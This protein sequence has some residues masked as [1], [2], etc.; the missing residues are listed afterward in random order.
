MYRALCLN[1]AT[2]RRA[3]PGDE[4]IMMPSCLVG[5]GKARNWKPKIILVDETNRQP[6][7]YPT[8]P[9]GLFS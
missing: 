7:S 9:S 1:G 6:V 4:V 8:G 3:H 2:A 5:D